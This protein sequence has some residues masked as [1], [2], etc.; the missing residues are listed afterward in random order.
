MK[1]VS[2]CDYL[3]LLRERIPSL[4]K[5]LDSNKTLLANPYTQHQIV[6]AGTQWCVTGSIFSDRTQ[7]VV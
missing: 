5:N 7:D 1:Y 3:Q 4:P 6:Y 2:T